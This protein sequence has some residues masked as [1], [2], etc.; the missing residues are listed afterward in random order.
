[1]RERRFEEAVTGEIEMSEVAEGADRRR[2]SASEE[3][4]SDGKCFEVGEVFEE[5]E[6]AGE[7]VG[8]DVEYAETREGGEL[9][10]D[11]A[12]E[13]VVGDIKD[14]EFSTVND[15]ERE[16]VNEFVVSD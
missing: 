2:N 14:F 8:G 3:V 13:E 11:F 4:V 10:R 7:F 9:R 12:G 5:I 1:M 6:V 16:L 15:L